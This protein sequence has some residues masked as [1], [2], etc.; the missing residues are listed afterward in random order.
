MIIS[1]FKWYSHSNCFCHLSSFKTRSASSSFL[2]QFL[3]QYTKRFP[4]CFFFCR[5]P[6]RVVLRFKVTRSPWVILG[7]WQRPWLVV[8]SS[9]LVKTYHYTRIGCDW[10]SLAGSPRA[11]PYTQGRWPCIF[12]R[13]AACGLRFYFSPI[14]LRISWGVPWGA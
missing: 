5:F 10:I 12:S 9:C 7:S 3:D 8:G 2:H 1:Y 13:T 6:C 4:L 11:S 14:C